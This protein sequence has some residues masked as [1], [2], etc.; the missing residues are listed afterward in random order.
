M[1][2]MSGPVHLSDPFPEPKPVEGCDV[3]AE[4]VR[5]RTEHLKHW[6][7]ALAAMCAVELGDHVHKVKGTSS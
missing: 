7:Y 6:R 5:Q 2:G 1:T 4:L 3:C